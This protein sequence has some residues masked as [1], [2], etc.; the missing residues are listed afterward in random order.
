MI[1]TW[2]ECPCFVSR[3]QPFPIFDSL[4]SRRLLFSDHAS[5]DTVVN[6]SDNTSCTASLMNVRVN[7][8]GISY[9][10]QFYPCDDCWRGICHQTNCDCSSTPDFP[11]HENAKLVSP[12]VSHHCQQ[13]RRLIKYLFIALKKTNRWQFLRFHPEMICPRASVSSREPSRNYRRRA[14]HII[15]RY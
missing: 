8:L 6:N 14:A 9:R 15:T 10:N 7:Y 12:S 4:T 1:E 11:T 3:L 2:S 13:H 5:G